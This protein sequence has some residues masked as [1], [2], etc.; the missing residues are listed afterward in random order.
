MEILGNM[1]QSLGYEENTLCIA[2]SDRPGPGGERQGISV[3]A[4]RRFSHAITHIVPL[5]LW[6]TALTWVYASSPYVPS[7]A[8]EMRPNDQRHGVHTRPNGPPTHL[9]RCR[10]A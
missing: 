5:R 4:A 10:S 8:G 1:L 7:S 6:W 9:Y 3:T 2:T